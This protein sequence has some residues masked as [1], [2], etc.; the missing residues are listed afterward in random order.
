MA[1]RKILITGGGGFIGSV[2]TSIFLQNNYE[3]VVIDNFSKGFKEPLKLLQEKFTA[4]KLRYYK[5][6]IRDNLD[7]VFKQE[8]ID[9]VVHFAG[10]CEVDESM[11][12]P[13]KYF[14]NNTY[15]SLNL[16]STMI[17]YNVRKIIFSSTCAVYGKALYVPVDEKHPTIPDNPYGQSKLMA[18]QIISWY[19]KLFDLKYV[20][21]R[22]FN[23]CGASDDGLIG[24]SQKPHVRLVHNAVM[25]VLGLE[26]FFLTCQ[27]VKTRDHTPIRDFINVVDLSLAHL[28][29]ANYLLKRGS[30]EIINLGTG[31]GY[32]VL[33]IIKAVKKATKKD[34]DLKSSAPRV[35]EVA[36]MVASIKKAKKILDWQPKRTIKDSVSSLVK[37]Y[38]L[39]PQGW[40]H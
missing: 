28:K 26:Q 5:A 3:V 21:L 10:V 36:K 34:F 4:K 15:G 14:S 39:H 11:K 33:E 29:A 24:D 18:E 19:G 17:K 31:R 40:N 30:S 9:L 2:A 8:E 27:Q 25:G 37:W 35:G 1:K 22:Y 23:V 32:S 13:Q 7:S 38:N 12:D 20:V 16:L 6:D